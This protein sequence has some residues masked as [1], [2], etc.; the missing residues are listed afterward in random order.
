MKGRPE[1]KQSIQ[2]N[3]TASV[4]SERAVGK[5]RQN[6]ELPKMSMS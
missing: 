2:V 4:L 5:Y 1:G 6:K 3:G